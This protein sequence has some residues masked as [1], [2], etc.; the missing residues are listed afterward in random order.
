MILLLQYEF[1]TM[2]KVQVNSIQVAS[3]L[4]QCTTQAVWKTKSY[5]EN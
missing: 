2:Q 5:F 4:D 3:D 1:Q